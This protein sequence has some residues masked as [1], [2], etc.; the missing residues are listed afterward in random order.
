MVMCLYEN[1]L[2][3]L[4][5]SGSQGLGTD[6]LYVKTLGQLADEHNLKQQR[7][8]QQHKQDGVVSP[9]QSAC[10]L[11]RFI[12]VSDLDHTMVQN[13]DPTHTHLLEFNHTWNARL[14]QDSVLVFSTG[15]SPAL[16]RKLWEEAPLLTPHVL[17][18]SVGTEMF[19]L[20][21]QHTSAPPSLAPPPNQLVPNKQSDATQLPAAPG[22]W[23][24]RHAG[25]EEHLNQ[26]GW[27][28][29]KVLHIASL[30]PELKP[31]DPS[32]QR[33]HKISFHLAPQQQ[34]AGC[35]AASQVLAQL[36]SALHAAFIPAKV[37][38]S[39]GQDVDILPER[40]GKGRA[41]EF[42]LQQVCG[43][44]AAP[45]C[46]EQD[47]VQ[48]SQPGL[49]SGAA[50]S[51]YWPQ[52]GVQVNGDSGNDVELFQVPHVKGCVVSNAHPELRA[53]AEQHALSNPNIFQ[54]TA[55]CAGGI[56][57]A[58]THFGTLDGGQQQAMDGTTSAT[59]APLA[60]AVTVG[61][62]ANQLGGVLTRHVIRPQ[63]HQVQQQQQQADRPL[64]ALAPE[65]SGSHHSEAMVPAAAAGTQ[66]TCCL[67]SELLPAPL[68]GM[69]PPGGLPLVLGVGLSLQTL[70]KGGYE[71]QLNPGPA[72]AGTGVAAEQQAAASAAAAPPRYW[73][74]LV[75]LRPNAEKQDGKA[76]QLTFQ[77]FHLTPDGGRECSTCEVLDC[78]AELGLPLA[79]PQGP[80]YG[81]PFVLAHGVLPHGMQLLG[82]Q[83]A[84]HAGAFVLPE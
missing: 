51:T 4:P 84:C 11:P 75:T 40:A 17:I 50:P 23:Y 77:I 82:L 39:G 8:Q 38:Y 7:L 26:G 9:V 27:D 1:V 56:L 13:E 32:E 2:E 3:P 24:E 73:S 53:F 19:I 43:P 76:A 83:V 70:P 28:R 33:P 58:M 16:Y 15:R 59:A 79:E 34:Q 22:L 35:R 81:E 47:A 10:L 18:C 67:P 64:P 57:Q 46:K 55:P 21:T 52:L 14:G 66:A 30:F 80:G 37:I 74:D 6:D 44:H 20:R 60:A 78:V 65:P 71:G 36:H 29:D 72:L 45:P 42:L 61:M 62:L 31:Q 41:L 69:T 5:T 25:W 68:S 49:S 54:A 63:E 12:L 48:A